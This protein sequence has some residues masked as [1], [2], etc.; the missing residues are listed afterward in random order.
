MQCLKKRE[1]LLS[2]LAA[3]KFQINSGTFIA[4]LLFRILATVKNDK[5]ITVDF[6]RETVIFLLIKPCR[7]LKRCERGVVATGF[8]YTG[9]Y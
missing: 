4:M 3:N 5:K 7:L 6:S 1:A 2:K 9:H 8:F